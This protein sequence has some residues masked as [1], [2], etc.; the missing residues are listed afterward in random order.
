M[1]AK[2]SIISL[3]RDAGQMDEE[4]IFKDSKFL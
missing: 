4:S 2:E 3:E 1:Q